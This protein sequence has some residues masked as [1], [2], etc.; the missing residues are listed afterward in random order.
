MPSVKQSARE[1]IDSL[2]DQATW[3]DLM[4]EFYA[5]QKIDQG[6]ADIEAGRTVPH[7][8][9]KAELLADED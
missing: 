8:E 3:D 4:Y 6:L 2:P 9:V 7:E 5:K 1:V